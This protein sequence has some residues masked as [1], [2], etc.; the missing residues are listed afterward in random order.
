MPSDA[1]AVTA[2]CGFLKTDSSS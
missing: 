2:V 1:V